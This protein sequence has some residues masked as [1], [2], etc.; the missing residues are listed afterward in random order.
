MITRPQNQHYYAKK[1]SAI[2][3]SHGIAEVDF[4]SHGNP[5]VN[6]RDEPNLPDEVFISAYDRGNNSGMVLLN[7]SAESL[8]KGS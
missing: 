5:Y 3:K 6:L 2:L 4:D 7:L 8:L 1:V